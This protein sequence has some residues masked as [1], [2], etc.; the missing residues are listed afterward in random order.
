M[1]GCILGGVLEDFILL[2]NYSLFSS[3]SKG[4]DPEELYIK[5]EKI[6]KGS[7]GEV[8]KG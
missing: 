1:I 5:Q 6:G 2:D 8:F 7:F 3:K 4:K